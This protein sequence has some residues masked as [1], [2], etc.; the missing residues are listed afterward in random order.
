MR[1]DLDALACLLMLIRENEL[2]S[3]IGEY[4]CC[5]RQAVH[6]VRRLSLFSPFSSIAPKMYEII[7]A[8]F[9]ERND[10][11]TLPPLKP[12]MAIEKFRRKF[13]IP[14]KIPLYNYKDITSG[15][16]WHAETRKIISND[17][18]EQ[19]T[20]LFW[21]DNYINKADLDNTLKSLSVDFDPKKPTESFPQPLKDLMKK[22][23]GDSRRHLPTKPSL[24]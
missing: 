18:N 11:L 22:F 17:E 10:P 4:L 3:K 2:N 1:N 16:L 19:L 24:F 15:I 14:V 20:F 5:K 7:Y 13:D 21:V 23:K 9:I 6:L 8:S 12:F